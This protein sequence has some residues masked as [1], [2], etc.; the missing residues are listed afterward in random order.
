MYVAYCM[1]MIPYKAFKTK[2]PISLLLLLKKKWGR[3]GG[4]MEEIE[5]A[6]K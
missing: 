5:S 4:E 2:Y 1:L 3:G 6:C